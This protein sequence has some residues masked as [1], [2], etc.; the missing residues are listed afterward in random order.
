MNSLIGAVLG[1]VLGWF[2]HLHYGS[3]I[4]AAIT[5]ISGGM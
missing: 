3:V 4:V 5:R 1:A 2:A